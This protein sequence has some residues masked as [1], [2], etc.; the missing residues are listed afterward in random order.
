MTIKIDHCKNI[1]LTKALYVLRNAPENNAVSQGIKSNFSVISV[2]CVK[3]SPD[4]ENQFSWGSM[5]KIKRDFFFSESEVARVPRKQHDD[6]EPIYGLVSQVPASSTT[7]TT[8]A[9][10]VIYFCAI[11]ILMQ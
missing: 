3:S 7:R 1:H 10:S 9:L 4:P 6:D 11:P 8:I 5:E 2:I